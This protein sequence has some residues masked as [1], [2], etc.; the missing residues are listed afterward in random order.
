MVQ[1][2]SP[3]RGRVKTPR[4]IKLQLL[5]YKYQINSNESIPTT[6]GLPRCARNDNNHRHC[7][8]TSVPEAI[9]GRGSYLLA[10]EGTTY[11]LYGCLNTVFI[12]SGVTLR[13]SDK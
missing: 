9:S 3:V 12:L 1:Y 8:V 6:L 11:K 5:N 2:I 13:G 4:E 10:G 7:E